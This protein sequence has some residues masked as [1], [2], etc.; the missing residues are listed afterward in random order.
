MDLLY[1]VVSSYV[2][3]DVLDVLNVLP[4]GWCFPAPLHVNISS[5]FA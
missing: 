3:V 1:S 4:A 5:C 2:S